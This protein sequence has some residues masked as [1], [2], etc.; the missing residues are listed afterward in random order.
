MSAINKI[1]KESKKTFI[2]YSLKNIENT[3]NYYKKLQ[4]ENLT[5]GVIS[6]PIYN[7]EN[8]QKDDYN[9]ILQRTNYLQ[10]EIVADEKDYVA[11]FITLTLPSKYHPFTQIEKNKYKKN[12]N[13]NAELSINDGYKELNRMMTKIQKDFMIKTTFTKKQWKKHKLKFI[14]VIEYHKSFVPHL[15]A[16]VF[17]EREFI[18]QFKKHLINIFAA[19]IDRIKTIKSHVSG[20][21]VNKTIYE[22]NENIGRSEIE[23][24][25]N[26]ERGVSYLLKYIRKSLNAENI[27]DKHLLDGWKKKNK[28]RIFTMSNVSIPRYIYKKLYINLGESIEKKQDERF[29]ILE[30]FEEICDINVRT[31][32]ENELI[33]ERSFGNKTNA[34]RYIITIEK[35]KIE[36]EY[37]EDIEVDE[38]DFDLADEDEIEIRTQYRIDEFIIYDTKKNK[39]IYNKKDYKVDEID[40]KE[41]DLVDEHEYD[42]ILNKII[43][44]DNQKKDAVKF[45]KDF[46]MTA[47]IEKII[48]DKKQNEQK[49]I[50]ELKKERTQLFFDFDYLNDPLC[51]SCNVKV[52]NK[53]S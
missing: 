30:K 26:V 12:P 47:N 15:H 14:K 8:I 11:F 7:F 37:Y 27:T 9:N 3:R 28:I 43:K 50:E 34:A 44:K 1:L 22:S 35:E 16:I 38:D 39:E 41:S 6:S 33:S 17:I 21:Y 52:F 45:V 51:H 24:L 46:N 31:F 10:N 23:E 29:N 32:F 4:I 53:V 36:K 13:Y 25:E 42:I 48:K 5:T 40:I 18:E 20:K 2:D 19:D 49:E